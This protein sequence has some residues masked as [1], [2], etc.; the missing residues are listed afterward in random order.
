MNKKISIVGAG[1]SG[2]LSVLYFCTK[3]PEYDITW[4]YPEDNVTIGVGEGTVPQVTEFLND[5]G[6]TYK[7]VIKDMGGSLKLGVKFE[8]F[9]PENIV[10]PFGR[11]EDEAAQIEYMIKYDKIPTNI[12]SLDISYH[13]SVEQLAKF[14]D[15]WFIKFNNLK[16]ERRL[17][18][19]VDEVDCE[20][21]IDCTGF[22][23]AFVS[24]YFKDNL[25]SISDRVP[26]NAALVYRTTI[27]EH[28]RNAY[29]TCIGMNHGWVWNIPLRDEIGIGYVYNDKYNV[30]EEFLDYLD[31]E[32]FG[33]PEVR[34]VKM[35]TGRNRHHYKDLGKKKIVS[36]GLSSAFIEPIEATGLYLT[37]YAIQELDRLMHYGINEEQFNNRINHEFDVIID[38]IVAHYK[39][40][41]HSNDYWSF[42]KNI[43]IQLHRDNHIFPQRSWD[44]ILQ[45]STPKINDNEINKLQNQ[46]DYAEWLKGVLNDN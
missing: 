28:K 37:T 44:Y 33:R 40:S 21:L 32:G 41:H 16:I 8:N 36:I 46:L 34:N 27:P 11:L 45:N 7:H 31:R 18:N 17:V 19:S 5:L 35:I 24:N 6:I 26:N 1:T 15:K 25:E 13:F 10:H 23:R 2:Y 22:K 43:N 12:E 30:K 14:L 4:I 3:Y 38:F 39:Y 20:W 42:Y 9:R 29:T